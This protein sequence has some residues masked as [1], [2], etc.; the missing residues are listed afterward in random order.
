[1]QKVIRLSLPNRP[2][3]VADADDLMNHMR[4]REWTAIRSGDVVIIEEPE[5]D[6][7]EAYNYLC[8][9]VDEVGPN[10]VNVDEI[11]IMIWCP[12]ENHWVIDWETYKWMI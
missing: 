1:M 12:G 10:F 3:W 2:D 6:G 4:S 8:N 9:T 5:C 11:G 7:D